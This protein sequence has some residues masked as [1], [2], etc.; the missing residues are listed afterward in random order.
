MYLILLTLIKQPM[1]NT[2]IVTLPL[3]EIFME[4]YQLSLPTSKAVI[5]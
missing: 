1:T 2:G 5:V 3:M 4:E